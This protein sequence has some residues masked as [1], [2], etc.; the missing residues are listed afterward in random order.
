M[1]LDSVP[2]PAYPLR[3]EIAILEQM[4]NKRQ[5][6]GSGYPQIVV[7]NRDEEWDQILGK[8]GE[9]AYETGDDRAWGGIER[10][11]GLVSDVGEG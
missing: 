9:R 11:L 7:A 4:R 10:R 8:L 6:A 1:L 3:F 5:R 2:V